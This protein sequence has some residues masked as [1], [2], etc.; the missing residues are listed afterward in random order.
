MAS[1]LAYIAS[2]KVIP[3]IIADKVINLTKSD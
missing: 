3:D 1:L 2:S